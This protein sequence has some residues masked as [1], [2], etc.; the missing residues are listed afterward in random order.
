MEGG[1]SFRILSLAQ[2]WLI[3]IEMYTHSSYP[4]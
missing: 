1:W 3:T 4:V 2:G